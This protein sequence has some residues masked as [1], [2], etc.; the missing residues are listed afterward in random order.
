LALAGINPFAAQNAVAALAIYVAV[1]LFMNLGAFVIV[2]FLR[3]EMQSEQIADYAGLLRRSPLVAVCF[4]IILV[5]LIGIPPLSGFYGKFAVFAALTEG[6]RFT[7]EPYLIVLF[8]IGG[9]NTVISLFYYLRVIR[10]MTMQPEPETRVPFSIP[11][12][13]LHGAYICLLTIPTAALC[14]LWDRLGEAAIAATRSM[15][16]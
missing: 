10:V 14:F 16:T 6:F 4:S 15:L 11:L 2:A 9:L 5:G 12:A 1:Y 7:G 3:N 13:T 8:A